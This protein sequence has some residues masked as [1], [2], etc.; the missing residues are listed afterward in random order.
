MPTR[1]TNSYQLPESYWKQTLDR[2]WRA[3]VYYGPSAAWDRAENNR[4]RKLLI[5]GLMSIKYI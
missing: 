5:V 3:S 4:V 1:S 2:S